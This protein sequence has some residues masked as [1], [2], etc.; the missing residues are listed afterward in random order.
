MASISDNVTAIIDNIFDTF[1]D[2]CAGNF[3][4]DE[5]Y[6]EATTDQK[7][8]L[9]GVF[10]SKK[11]VTL[12]FSDG[13]DMIPITRA[14]TPQSDTPPRK[15][16]MVRKVYPLLSLINACDFTEQELLDKILSGEYVEITGSSWV[17]DTWE[18]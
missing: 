5:L 12:R 13:E 1:E 7:N 18:F 11:N 8:E 15:E 4:D 16:A 14:I 9:T 2:I 3:R 10:I 17:N 6:V